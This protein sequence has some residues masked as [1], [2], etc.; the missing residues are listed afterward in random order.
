MSVARG[1]ALAGAIL[2]AML[3]SPAGAQDTVAVVRHLLA[4][5]ISRLQPFRRTYDMLLHGA[6]SVTVIGQREVTL[7]TS[8]YAGSVA[9]LL[10]ES[11]SGAVSSAESLYV[12]TDVRPIHWSSVLGVSRLAAEFV[13]D[14]ILGAVVVGTSRQSLVIAG[15]PDLLVSAAMLETV[16][17]LL[18]LDSTWS[19]SANV[20]AVTVA[21]GEVTPAALLVVAMEDLPVDARLVRPSWVVAMRTGGREVLYWV[22]RQSGAV[23]RS[24]QS[25]PTHVGRMLEYRARADAPAAAP[26]H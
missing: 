1:R 15:R 21:S 6:D 23:L 14:S 12:A 13:G 3:G 2:L 22:D 19:D 8:T 18:P 16:L 5:D 11:R 10:V 17:S 24:V 4:L 7:D 25:V 9:W 26:L 20:L